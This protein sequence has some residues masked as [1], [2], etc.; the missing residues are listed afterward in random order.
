MTAFMRH[1]QFYC[2]LH[3]YLDLHS[4]IERSPA[5]T[6]EVTITERDVCNLLSSGVVTVHGVTCMFDLAQ[7]LHQMP[8]LT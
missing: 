4:H 5:K 3:V 2:S 6:G 8:F 7:V 1:S